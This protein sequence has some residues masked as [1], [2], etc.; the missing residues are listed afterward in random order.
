MKSVL[1]GFATLVFFTA[2]AT[3]CPFMKSAEYQTMSV[4]S[5]EEA[6]VPMSTTHDALADDVVVDEV[7]TGAVESKETE[8]AE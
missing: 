5:L 1:A 2:A 7:T 3:A 8:T 6:D 4:A